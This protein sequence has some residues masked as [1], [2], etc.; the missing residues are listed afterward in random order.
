MHAD[1]TR[2]SWQ[3]LGSPALSEPPSHLSHHPCCV[4]GGKVAEQRGLGDTSTDVNMR[5]SRGRV[6][7]RGGRATSDFYRTCCIRRAKRFQ[8]FPAQQ[9]PGKVSGSLGG[10]KSNTAFSLTAWLLSPSSFHSLVI[11][12]PDSEPA[13]VKHAHMGFSTER[14]DAERRPCHS[15]F[16]YAQ[17]PG[18]GA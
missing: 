11:L 5:K 6:R 3:G 14:Q 2:S 8:P 15:A 17:C 9:N 16:S 13:G 12:G 1:E 10:S 18:R 7:S 4:H